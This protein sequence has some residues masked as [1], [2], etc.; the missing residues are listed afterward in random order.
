MEVG[1]LTGAPTFE[2]GSDPDGNSEGVLA[3]DKAFDVGGGPG[4]FCFASRVGLRS[5]RLPFRERIPAFTDDVR[6]LVVRGNALVG[7][8]SRDVSG[9]GAADDDVDVAEACD[10]NF[11]GPESVF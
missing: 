3:D 1:D 8:G 7:E 6:E 10:V 2:L 4:L 9:D 5:C 11:D